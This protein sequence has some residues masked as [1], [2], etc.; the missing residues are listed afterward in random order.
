MVDK[1][2]MLQPLVDL[3]MF[4]LVQTYNSAITV[5]KNRAQSHT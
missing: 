2:V 5:M 3:F 1:S 4:K